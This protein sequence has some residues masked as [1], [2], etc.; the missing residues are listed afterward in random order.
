MVHRQHR[1]EAA[2]LCRQEGGVGRQRASQV[3]A[4]AAQ[5]FQQ[6]DDDVQLFAAEVAVLAGVRVQAE[7][8]DARPGQAEVAAQRGM[9]GGDDLAQAIGGDGVG[10]IAQRQVGGGQGH[11]HVFVGQHHHHL[12]AG[13]VGQQFG[14][15]AVGDA[16]CV[17]R[18]LVHRAGDHAVESALQAG[19]A[20]AE[21]GVDHRA[22][23][24]RIGLAEAGRRGIADFAQAQVARCGGLGVLRQ[25]VQGQVERGRGGAQHVRVGEHQQPAIA[26]RLLDEADAQFRADP[27]RLARDQS[28]LGNHRIRAWPGRPPARRCPR[29]GRRCGS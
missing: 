9:G 12:D 3:Q 21:Q 1:V 6:R 8:R 4:L 23:V 7:H 25:Q 26:A 15:A 13:L 17:D 18:R 29:R 20:G 16:A 28:E 2:Q 27:G 10:D 22:G 24:G 5:A 14:G 19:P 11:A